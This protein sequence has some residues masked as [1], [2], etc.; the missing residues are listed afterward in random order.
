MIFDTPSD[1]WSTS[2]IH[3]L[4]ISALVNM[5]ILCMEAET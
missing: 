2:G 4:R 5:L 3:I 1:I